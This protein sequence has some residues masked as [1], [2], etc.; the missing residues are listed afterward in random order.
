MNGG[1][2]TKMEEENIDQEV[3][4]DTENKICLITAKKLINEDDFGNNEVKSTL[5]GWYIY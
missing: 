5:R 4:T 2:G 3:N 1:R